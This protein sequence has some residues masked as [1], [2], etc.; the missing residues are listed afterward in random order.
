MVPQFKGSIVLVVF[1]LLS[2][3][4][5]WTMSRSLESDMVRYD[6]FKQYLRD[7]RIE[8]V[9]LGQDEITGRFKKGQI[10]AK[11]E[12]DAPPEDDAERSPFFRTYR[13]ADEKLVEE[14]ES[15][16][17]EYSG[18]KSSDGSFFPFFIYLG[19][20]LL[21]FMLLTGGLARA[22]GGPANVLAFG[23]SKGK[24]F[25]END[26]DVT[27]KDVAGI[28]EAKGELQEIIDFL[29]NPEKYHGLGAKIPKG[30]L[31]VGP[32]GTGKTLLARAVA[33]E[34]NVPFISINGSEFVEMFVG[35][36][37]SRVRDLFEQ[38][39]KSAPCIVFI[40]ELDAIGRSRTGAVMGGGSNEERE[41]TLNQ[42]LVEL[43]GFEPHKAVIIM[44]ATNRPE[45]LDPALLRPGRFDRQIL[46][47]RPDRNGRAAILRV[48]AQHVPLEDDV[49]LERIAAQTSGFAGAD[50]A[51]LV[52][53]AAL[54]A[55]RRGAKRVSNRDFSAAIDRVV[56]GLERKSR[57]I[58]DEEKRRIAVHEIGHAI[59]ARCSGTDQTVHKISIIPHG[60]AALGYTRKHADEDRQIMTRSMLECELVSLL[61]GR[62]AELL[63]FGEASTGASNDLQHATEI[64]R[65]MVTEYGM[66]DAVGPLALRGAGRS[67]FLKSLDPSLGDNYGGALADRVDSEVRA[68]LDGAQHRAR[69]ILEH[70]REQLDHLADRLLAAEQLEGEEL[71][72]LLAQVQPV[73]EEPDDA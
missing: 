6:Q 73:P 36:G 66:S 47:D 23:K 18:T 32:P 12:D 33:G 38:A 58:S 55:A 72:E 22:R 2:L 52:N 25:A 61:G 45:I 5:L 60:L 9:Q 41:Q 1:L 27:F 13:V 62:G 44:S 24:V 53:E 71:Q 42:L 7:G 20:G 28:E 68:V 56:A 49:D 35:V 48:H 16:G 8:S 40:D 59:A 11:G 37:A 10:P 21:L 19:L 54:A 15:Q 69:R 29:K 50:L 31:L 63:V 64:A 4:M 39:G 67:P 14:L 17:V 26:V 51:N 34:A 30:V 3:L 65:A 43:D 70:N 46:V 57:L